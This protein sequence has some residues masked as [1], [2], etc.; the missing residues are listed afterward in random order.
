MDKLNWFMY[1][2]F[3]GM[4]VMVALIVFMDWQHLQGFKETGYQM[5][6]NGVIYK[7][8]PQ[9]T[10]K[11]GCVTNGSQQPLPVRATPTL[12]NGNVR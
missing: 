1:G 7:L 4:I 2:F 5:Q 12:P 8:V 3:S 6:V 9:T 11:G 10:E